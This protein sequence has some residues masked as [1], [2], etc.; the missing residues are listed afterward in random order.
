MNETVFKYFMLGLDKPLET[1]REEEGVLPQPH[2][3]ER[4]KRRLVKWRV[5]STP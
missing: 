1:S 4:P 2:Q 5:D 3:Q